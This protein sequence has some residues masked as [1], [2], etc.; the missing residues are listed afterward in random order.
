MCLYMTQY[1]NNLNI[2]DKIFTKL[3]SKIE[4]TVAKYRIHFNEKQNPSKIFSVC[5]GDP[6]IKAIFLKNIKEAQDLVKAITEQLNKENL[7]V[8]NKKYSPHEE[9]PKEKREK[10]LEYPKMEIKGK[11]VTAYP[12]DPSKYPHI[13]HGY[14][15][16]INYKFAKM[17]NGKFILRF[18]DTNPTIVRKEYYTAIL[19]GLKWLGIIPDEV[20]N[21]SDYIEKLYD[22]TRKFI[23]KGYAYIC[24]CDAETVKRNRLE[25]KECSCRNRTPKENLKD[26]EDLILG[27]YNPGEKL[28]RLKLDMKSKRAEMRDP[29][30]M[31]I[32]FDEHPLVGKKYKLWPSYVWQNTFL[33][34]YNKVTHRFRSKEFEPWKPV[35]EKIAEMAGFEMPQIYEYARVNISGVKA[36]GREIREKVERGEMAWDDPRLTTLSALKRRGFTPTAIQKFIQKMG[37]SK[38]ESTAQW[39]VLESF[40]RKELVNVEKVAFFKNPKEFIINKEKIYVDPTN[41]KEDTEYRLRHFCN[42]IYKK[43]KLEECGNEIKKGISILP[44]AKEIQEITIVMDDASKEK[45]YIEKKPLK[46]TNY[47]FEGLGFVKIDSLKPLVAYFTHK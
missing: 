2:D 19:D 12:P 13:G 4:Q 43:G 1:V 31:R 25:K 34:H 16:Y 30:I 8:L 6:E 23:K 15:S 29:G 22:E 21:A 20:V 32:I 46:E 42:V 27:K 3:I 35:Q 36:S 18:E 24:S 9:K 47:F 39:S 14:A 10:K 7:E 40:N 17:H 33:D 45:G 37:L 38:T 28:V 44:F 5:M 11:V 26:F 41:L